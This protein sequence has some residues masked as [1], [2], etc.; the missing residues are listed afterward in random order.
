MKIGEALKTK[1]AEVAFPAA[2]V[3]VL[4][5]VLPMWGGTAMMAG[6]VVGLVAYTFLFRERLRSRGWWKPVVTGAV[7]AA[8][9]AAVAIVVSL[10]QGAFVL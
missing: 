8:V 5:L 2:L 3:V 6:S 7:A 1:K 9:A 4:F 10:S